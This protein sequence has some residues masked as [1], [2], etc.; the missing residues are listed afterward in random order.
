M[1]IESIKAASVAVAAAVE[2][3]EIVSR[4]L[5]QAVFDRTYG[6]ATRFRL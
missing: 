6:G 2:E 3:M 1:T 4:S 5:Q